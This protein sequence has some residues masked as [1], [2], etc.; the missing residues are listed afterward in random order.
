MTPIKKIQ[1][2]EAILSEIDKN[3]DQISY[4][5]DKEFIRSK[6]SKNQEENL[7]KIIALIKNDISREDVANNRQ[8]ALEYIR[9]KDSVS[10]GEKNT[11]NIDKISRALF[12]L[13]G[14]I[15]KYQVYVNN[16]RDHPEDLKIERQ[17]E[18]FKKLMYEMGVNCENVSIITQQALTAYDQLRNISPDGEF[19]KK[20]RILMKLGLDVTEHPEITR[21]FC[22]NWDIIEYFKEIETKD[23][24]ATEFFELFIRHV[25]EYSNIIFSH[26]SKKDLQLYKEQWVLRDNKNDKYNTIRNEKIDLKAV[27]KV[28]QSMKM[29]LYIFYIYRRNFIFMGEQG[30]Q[31]E[32]DMINILN[33]HKTAIERIYNILIA[34][35]VSI[36]DRITQ[37]HSF[38]KILSKTDFNE[39]QAFQIVKETNYLSD[40]N[41]R[42]IRAFESW[43]YDSRFTKSYEAALLIARTI[44]TPLVV[45]SI[46]KGWINEVRLIK[47]ADCI[48]KKSITKY[49]D[50][51]RLAALLFH[52][53]DDD[54]FEYYLML[55]NEKKLSI[56]EL[57]YA[58]RQLEDSKID[59]RLLND[60]VETY[61]YALKQGHDSDISIMLAKKFSYGEWPGK[62]VAIHQAYLYMIE[63]AHAFRISKEQL[64]MAADVFS[65][66]IL[67]SKY[68]FSEETLKSLTYTILTLIKYYTLNFAELNIFMKSISDMTSFIEKIPHIRDE[69]FDSLINLIRSQTLS[70]SDIKFLDFTPIFKHVDS[71]F[72]NYQI[73]NENELYSLILVIPVLGKHNKTALKSVVASYLALQGRARSIEDNKRTRDV[74]NAIANIKSTDNETKFLLKELIALI[75]TGDSQIIT[76]IRNRAIR[77]QELSGD[78]LVAYRDKIHNYYGPEDIALSEAL[79]KYWEQG[80]KYRDT[81]RGIWN[82]MNDQRQGFNRAQDINFEELEKYHKSISNIKNSEI[83]EETKN[84][85]LELKQLWGSGYDGLSL[86]HMTK[87]LELSREEVNRYITLN[88]EFIKKYNGFLE[89]AKNGKAVEAAK[90]MGDI[91]LLLGRTAS[92]DQSIRIYLDEL[93]KNME[94]LIYS[95]ASGQY[96]IVD[97]GQ[98][99]ELEQNGMVK[100]NVLSEYLRYIEQLLKSVM[101]SGM[102]DLSERKKE[103]D[104]ELTL[105]NN[106]PNKTYFSKAQ[107]ILMRYH[108][109]EKNNKPTDIKD[110]IEAM[111][112]I[113]QGIELFSRTVLLDIRSLLETKVTRAFTVTGEPMP[114]QHI[115]ERLMSRFYKVGAIYNLGEA[116]GAI[117][118]FLTGGKGV[119]VYEGEAYGKVKIVKNAKDAAEFMTGEVFIAA[120]PTPELNAAMMAASAIITEE[121]GSTSHAAMIAREHKKPCIVGLYKATSNFKSG[122]YLHIDT[123][124]NIVE[125]TDKAT[126]TNHEYYEYE[127][128]IISSLAFKE[129]HLEPYLKKYLRRNK[130]DYVLPIDNADDFESVGGKAFNLYILKQ[131]SNENSNIFTVPEGFVVTTTAYV[132]TILDNY[133]KLANIENIRVM[134]PENLDQKFISLTIPEEVRAQIESYY[135]MM[136]NQLNKHVSVRSSATTE[137]TADSTFAGMHE[138][139]LFSRGMDIIL[140]DI[141]KC[142]ASLYSQRAQIHRNKFGIDESKALMAVVVQRM[143]NADYA[144]VIYTA[145]TEDVSYYSY[146]KTSNTTTQNKIPKD[147]AHMKVEIVQGQGEGLVSGAKT[148]SMYVVDKSK[149]ELSWFQVNGKTDNHVND[150]MTKITTAALLIEK[151]YSKGRYRPQDIEF[152]VKGDRL[153]ILQSRDIAVHK[154]TYKDAGKENYV[155]QQGNTQQNSANKPSGIFGYIKKIFSI[156]PEDKKKE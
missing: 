149:S 63:R 18:T 62:N 154:N 27:E 53:D 66:T 24:T 73:Q 36:E 88:A 1:E 132:K 122:E 41:A 131:I 49:N 54:V 79:L 30:V 141:K 19:I 58:F 60:Q 26:M 107:I 55:I 43:V 142:W 33:N 103:G 112:L 9:W 138:S 95:Q 44:N 99:Y 120:N 5:E 56:D 91:R 128:K 130:T 32:L 25:K 117:L 108:L 92:I 135:N 139:F 34:P 140:R 81:F 137:D 75:P 47:L 124:K 45:E 29:L 4:P 85:I 133:T 78:I 3:I 74:I 50:I 61:I 113:N 98:R 87:E 13:D 21:L 39:N 129:I 94:Y 83:Y 152:C 15:L 40:Y 80:E 59:K 101:A 46:N 31:S 111:H 156:F 23:G 127:D 8:G 76:T 51:L 118:Q 114:K 65:N 68:F 116:A 20:K 69:F 148:P 64:L 57:D 146:D 52:E 22:E 125:K 48:D 147:D 97:K 123:S 136:G 102:N 70:Q 17:H 121:G 6:F 89:D 150:M 14:L 16:Y 72:K 115:I 145:L 11:E 28:K 86:E 134:S 38:I 155:E 110:I 7:K 151:A 144:G 119:V 84:I 109:D 93:L 67:F 96:K 71:S 104:E 82:E 2:A 100:T 35:E 42:S 126:A 105:E 10:R 106:G 143:V 12:S 77:I 90:I 153:Y 37:S